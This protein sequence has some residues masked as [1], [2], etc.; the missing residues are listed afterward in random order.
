MPLQKLAV[1]NLDDINQKRR[2]I[3]VLNQVLDHSFDDSRR[4]TDQEKVL[5][6]TPINP[7]YPEGDMRRYGV[8]ADDT[9]Q[10][11]NIV[12]ALTAL[13]PTYDGP[14]Y[15][16]ARVRFDTQTVIDAMPDGAVLY[17]TN[18]HQSGT[19]YRQQLTGV[20]T[21]PPDANTDTAFAIID[22]HYPDLMLN[23]P[24]TAGTDSGDKGLSGF[25]WAR[26]FFESGTK[27]PRIQWQANFT[28]SAVRTTEYS[29]NGVACFIMRT[30]SPERA[31]DFEYISEG[32]N[33]V[34][35][36]YYFNDANGAYYL[37]TTSG[38]QGATLPTHLS[39]SA[40]AGGNTFTFDSNWLT[41]KTAFYVDEYG[42]IGNE[43]VDT[44][45]TQVWSQNPSDTE[46]FNIQ[47]TAGGASKRITDK[48]RPTDSGSSAVTTIPYKDW[49]EADG[50]R[51]LSSTGRILTK[52]TDASGFQ[53]GQFGMLSFTA[54]DADTTPSINSCG[55]L[56]LANTGATSITTFDDPLPNQEV[57]LYATTANTTLVHS[58]ALV[59]KGAVNAALPA[60][61][62]LVIT[63]N[64]ANNAW[65][66]KSRNF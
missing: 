45:T 12:N 16:T 29:N 19:G 23:N 18:I 21:A 38:V 39:G 3:E 41:F 53:L 35:G 47:Y 58:S 44:G 48:R 31:G 6:V 11:T 56:V 9:D 49:T 27:G 34:S 46:D 17:F 63:R 54:A 55:R 61:G 64:P 52:A 62:I 20:I 57:E 2:R 33:V 10:T 5:G 66:E 15:I 43:Q 7:A 65:V 36:A 4:Q 40:A 42:R 32:T 24:R 22:P 51:L 8:V 59:L 50:E 37:A 30:R 26:G 13:G 60:N 25:S 1:Q 28:K 14:L